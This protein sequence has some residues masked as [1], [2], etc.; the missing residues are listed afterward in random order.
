M[1]KLNVDQKTIKA[2]FQDKRSDFVIPD[3]QRPYA[4]GTEECSTLWSDIVEFAFPNN[5]TSLFDTDSEYFL[6]PIVTFKNDNGKLEVIDGQQRLITLTLLLRAFYFG[7]EKMQDPD[8][9]S[10]REDIE[11][12][13]WKTDELNRVDKKKPKIVSEV[14]TDDDSEEFKQILQ[15]GSAEGM[16][17]R[18]AA[19]YTLFQKNIREFL[20][21]YPGYFV[22]LPARIM[23]NCI[24]L[25]IEAESQDTAL[26]IFSTLNDRGKPLADADIF[27]AQFYKYYSDQGRKDEF[28]QHWKALEVRCDKIFR[29]SSNSPMDELFIRYMYYLR[30]KD[31]NKNTTTEGL[32]RFYEKDSYKLLKNETALKDLEAIAEFWT[33]VHDQDPEVFSDEVLKKLYVLEYAPNS[34]WAYLL[35]VYYLMNRDE[36]GHLDD[37]SL[38]RFLDKT[39]ALILGYSVMRPGVN[40]LRT[41]VYPAM[42]DIVNG[43]E[44]SYSDVKIDENDL[45]DTMRVYT[46]SN[47]RPIT[48]SFLTWWMF[49][50][51]EQKL[52]SLETDFQIE[53][54]YSRNRAAKE[55]SRISDS[56]VE[57]LGNKAMLEDRINI[58][59]SDYRFSDKKPYYIGTEK[60]AGTADAELVKM[61]KEDLDFKAEDIDRR[62]SA[63]I[64]SFVSYIREN[65][66]LGSS[67]QEVSKQ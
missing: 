41:P 65:D 5:D 27:K 57:C 17:S 35:T 37:E 18:Y 29:D 2:L 60:R 13:L 34:M 38:L 20:E 23:N 52:I 4:W 11:K 67:V 40:A 15:S 16:S 31:G 12:C 26:R 9:K 58:R 59:A 53:H 7:F 24:L 3:Y 50:N 51:P 47:Q 1:S 43:R 63:M 22:Y 21:S 64:D 33:D 36:N 28:I 61:A 45:R 55:G 25:P 54:I 44:P 32:R 46:F 66:L 42:I 14:A 8:S 30:A 56:Q 48:R 39:T 19:T 62:E 6:G 49:R 10:I